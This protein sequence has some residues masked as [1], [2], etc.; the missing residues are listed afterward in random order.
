MIKAES[1]AA[2]LEIEREEMSLRSSMAQMERDWRLQVAE[3][4]RDIAMMKVA[5]DMNMNREQL[6]A[7]LAAQRMDADSKERKL[8][9]E[10]A[11]KRQTG[12]G[13]GGLV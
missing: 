12:I 8:A 13:A 2:R 3:T 11:D 1:D 10:V 5:E 6:D 9:V 4:Q 7:R